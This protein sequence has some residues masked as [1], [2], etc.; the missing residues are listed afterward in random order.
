MRKSW[1][2]A[3]AVIAVGGVTGAAIAGRPEPRDPFV[4]DATTHD[5]VDSTAVVATTIATITTTA[6]TPTTAVEIV[7]SPSSVA[8]TST[9][10]AT[11]VA[12]A[13]PITTILA[14]P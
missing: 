10:A 14:P 8:T 13:T 7:T 9:S 12:P 1:P 4:L 5:V 3:L 2:F 6:T 11:T